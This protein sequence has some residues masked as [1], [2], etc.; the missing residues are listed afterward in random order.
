MAKD[1]PLT[2]QSLTHSRHS[3]D[4]AAK[5][6]PSLCAHCLLGD[7]LDD[8]TDPLGLHMEPEQ[9]GW[10]VHEKQHPTKHERDADDAAD[11]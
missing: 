10:N 9:L 7:G 1:L 2:S 4:A 5:W 3:L 8:S 11:L 6:Q